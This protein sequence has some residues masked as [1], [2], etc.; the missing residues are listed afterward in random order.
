MLWT[1]AHTRTHK[2]VAHDA[3]SSCLRAVGSNGG[4]E[5]ER[6]GEV[7]ERK[8]RRKGGGE[9]EQQPLHTLKLHSRTTSVYRSIIAVGF[10]KA[11]TSVLNVTMTSL[12]TI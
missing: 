10:T 12:L 1:C 6:E 11:E 7:N 8:K 2:H 3:V 5:R 4:G 9:R